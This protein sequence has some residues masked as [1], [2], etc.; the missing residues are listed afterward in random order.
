MKSIDNLVEKALEGI[1]F[2]LGNIQKIEVSEKKVLLSLQND[3]NSYQNRKELEKLR[4]SLQ[5]YKK[6]NILDR[7]KTQ[8][9]YGSVWFKQVAI[10]GKADT[11]SNILDKLDDTAW[12]IISKDS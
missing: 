11:L 7:N 5:K 1:A 6:S 9:N 12:K 4:N 3:L 8:T 2:A 10:S